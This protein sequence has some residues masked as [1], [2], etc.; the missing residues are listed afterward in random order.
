MQEPFGVVV[1]EDLDGRVESPVERFVEARHDERADL[2]VVHAPDEAVLERMAE[3]AMA[4]VVQENGQTGAAVL[5]LGDHDALF[6]ERIEGLLHQV[7]S[8]QGV[9]EAVVDRTGIDQVAQAE[10]ADAAQAL[11]PR[12]IE[13]LGEI[14]VAELDEPVDRV[15]QQLGSCGHGPKIGVFLCTGATVT[16]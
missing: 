7:Q 10:L 4:D 13:D 2:L 5:V 15:V 16:K 12:V 11:H 14:R 3:G 8:A 9:V 1:I 6:A